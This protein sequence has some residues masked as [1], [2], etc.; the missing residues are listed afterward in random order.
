MR[1][2]ILFMGAALLACAPTTSST[3]TTSSTS[4][5]SAPVRAASIAPLLTPGMDITCNAEK[6]SVCDARG[7]R[8]ETDGMI[9]VA[10]SYDG[11]SGHGELCMGETCD[12]VT[13][14]ALPADAG[15][16]NVDIMAAIVDPGIQAEPD[17]PQ[18]RGVAIIKRDGSSFAL[19]H[20]GPRI[21]SGRCEPA[22]HE[23]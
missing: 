4:T 20:D 16:P 15:D 12:A 2:L 9:P 5:T 22:V 3:T 18:S 13:L 8:A 10:L 11:A 1:F 17:N 23:Q 6:E 21:W 14:T 19:V 7:C